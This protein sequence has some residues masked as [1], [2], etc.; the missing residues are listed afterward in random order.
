MQ[1]QV[2]DNGKNADASAFPDLVGLG[3]DRSCFDT[4][5]KAESYA[6]DWLG[7]LGNIKLKLN[8]PQDYNGY[9]DTIE[10]RGVEGWPEDQTPKI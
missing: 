7:K 1:Y 2:L 3:W 9:G 4:F 6:N 8:T 5:E 10:I